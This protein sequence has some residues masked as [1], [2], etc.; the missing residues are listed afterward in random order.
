MKTFE[1]LIVSD[2]ME[3]AVVVLIERKFR[4]PLYGKIVTWKKKFHATN[5]IGAQ[6][7]QWV[8]IAETKPVSKTISFKVTDILGE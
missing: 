6:K 1:G 5:E 7:G 3:K 8:R 4:H 2:K